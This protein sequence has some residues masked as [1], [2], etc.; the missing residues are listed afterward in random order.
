METINRSNVKTRREKKK[1][2]KK[3]GPGTDAKFAS[4]GK[5]R[6]PAIRVRS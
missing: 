1:D 6:H 3:I 2:T 5:S 4:E